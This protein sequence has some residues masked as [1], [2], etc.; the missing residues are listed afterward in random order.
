MR[1]VAK[2]ATTIGVDTNKKGL[3]Q[4]VERARASAGTDGG[5]RYLSGS[6]ADEATAP[7]VI[8]DILA[9]E[10]K[11]DVLVNLASILRSE[12]ATSTTLELFRQLLKVNLIGTFLFCIRYN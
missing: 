4:T 11:L 7:Q 12:S 8:A 1:L 9:N 3:H 5:A 10:S 6:V 2:G